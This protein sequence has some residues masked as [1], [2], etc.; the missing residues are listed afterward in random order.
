MH[1]HQLEQWEHD[2]KF[3]LKNEKGEKRSIQVLILT[4]TAMIAEITAGN[5]FDSMALIADGWQ[6]G[7]HTAALLISIFAY[8]YA[9]VN[10]SNPKFS[11]GTGKVTVL[12]G[13]A[14]AVA[15]ISVSALITLESILRLM[16]PGEIE[17]NGAITAAGAGLL[18]NFICAFLLF[19]AQLK[20]DEFDKKEDHTL[21]A[22]Y[23]NVLADTLTSIIA[24]GALLSG[25]FLGTHWLDPITGIAGALIIFRWSLILIKDTSAILLDNEIENDK[26]DKILN[27]LQANIRGG[28]ADIH[29]WKVGPADYAAIISIVTDAPEHP[30]QY[31]EILSE[32]SEIS[33]ITIEVN[34]CLKPPCLISK[35]SR[36][37]AG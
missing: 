26:K 36:L 24:I 35:M 5:I 15:L 22:A 27:K 25:K 37:R 7:T 17:Y 23:L 28:V 30:E 9:K 18:I 3:Y 12:G 13:F 20:P 2:H 19:N 32:F 14:S 8:R 1:T 10:S 4:L 21:R 33:H 6:M 16:N 31:K 29:I 11:F 34:R